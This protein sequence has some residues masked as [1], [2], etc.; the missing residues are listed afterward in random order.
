MEM[1]KKES[2][3]DKLIFSTLFKY[4]PKTTMKETL[5][6]W[7]RRLQGLNYP[8][9][10]NCGKARLEQHNRL[11]DLLVCPLCWHKYKKKEALEGKFI[12]V[13]AKKK[14]RWGLIPSGPRWK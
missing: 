8:L 7:N 3:K 13:R 4:P 10:P 1:T 6:R 2:E 9:C 5:E 11:E 14:V 12:I